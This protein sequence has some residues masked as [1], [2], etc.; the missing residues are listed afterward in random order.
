MLDCCRLRPAA[1]A[2]AGPPCLGTLICVFMLLSPSLFFVFLSVFSFK[3]LLFLKYAELSGP[4]QQGR[5]QQARNLPPQPSSGPSVVGG[6]PRKMRQQRVYRPHSFNYFLLPFFVFIY[7]HLPASSLAFRVSGETPLAK[8]WQGPPTRGG[9]P[10]SLTSFSPASSFLRDVPSLSATSGR[11]SASSYFGGA[12]RGALW[13]PPREPLV[14]GLTK[15]KRNKMK[16]ARVG[17]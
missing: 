10:F 13:G 3:A 17:F 7:T 11:T 4:P 16:K 12:P 6:P 9:P 5:P 1:A 14:E 15:N 2:P 8:D